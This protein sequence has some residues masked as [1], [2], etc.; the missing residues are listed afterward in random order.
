LEHRRRALTP[1]QVA[2]E[3]G[4]VQRR[5]AALDF[6]RAARTL[7]L[8]DAQP[9]EVPTCALFEEARARGVRCAYP[10]V[11]RGEKLLRFHEVTATTDLISG[12]LGIA[13]PSPAAP[14]VALE[15]IDCFVVPGVGFTRDGARLGRGG[16]H[17]DATLSRRRTGAWAVGLAFDACMVAR[18]PVD[19]WDVWVDAIVSSKETVVLK[20]FTPR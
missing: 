2:Q 7:A 16:G 14:E 19:P 6:F 5:L 8:Y 10:R 3:G 9:F 15:D 20:D 17:Y 18:L 4:E 12:P 11:V 1:A 13:Q